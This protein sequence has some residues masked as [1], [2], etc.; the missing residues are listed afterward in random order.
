[1]MKVP[2]EDQE[3][4]CNQHDICYDTC[5]SNDVDFNINVWIVFAQRENVNGFLLAS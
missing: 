5:H 2:Y 1:M 3:A 4:C